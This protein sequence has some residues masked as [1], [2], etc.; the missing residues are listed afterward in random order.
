MAEILCNECGKPFKG[1]FWE[2]CCPECNAKFEREEMQEEAENGKD[3][4]GGNKVVCPWCFEEIEPDYQEDSDYFE[5]GSKAM[6]CPE[7]GKEYW[8]DVDVSYSYHSNR[9]LPGWLIED[10]KRTEEA[11]RKYEEYM[12]QKAVEEHKCNH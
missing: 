11:R 12:K 8:L 9:N 3:I 2:Y 7:C 5:E 1:E 6:I 4:Y 10:R